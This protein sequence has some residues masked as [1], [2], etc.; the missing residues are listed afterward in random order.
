MFE[1]IVANLLNK[2][3]GDYVA[4]LET[5]QLKIGI[6]HG[7]VKLNNLQLRKE[8]LDK[9]N[10]PIDVHEGYIG[11]LVLKIPWSN[12]KGEPVRVLL[13]NIFVLAG[14]KRLAEYD[15]EEDEQRRQRRKQD[16]LE[17]LEMLSTKPKPEAETDA[18]QTSFTMQ[19]VTKIVDNL[20]ISIH[21]IHIRYE[22]DLSNPEHLFAAGI[23][24]SELSAVSTDE[25]WRVQFIDQ[26]MQS[27]FKLLRMGHLAV[28]F[29]SNT[30]SLAGQS[31]PDF[32]QSFSDLISDE[33]RRPKDQMYI[34]KPVS[35]IGRLVLNKKFT[36]ST[37]KSTATFLFDQLAFVLDDTQYKDLL[38]LV[39]SF[40]YSIRQHRYLK[41]R[42]PAH[43]KVSDNARQWLQFAIEC[44]LSEVK[45]RRRRWTWDYFKERR[46][47]RQR[48]MRLYRELQTNPNA[49]EEKK[50]LTALERK[51]SFQDIRFYRSRV[52]A[53]LRKE[54]AVTAKQ[55]GPVD[56]RSWV[57]SWFGAWSGGS[58]TPEQT[59][60]SEEQ[61]QELYDTIEF[62]EQEVIPDYDLPK[63]CVLLEVN[64]QLNKGSFTVQQASR[65]VASQGYLAPSRAR[66]KSRQTLMSMNF[67]TF[68]FGFTKHPSSFVAKLSLHSFNIL[69]GTTEHSLYPYL[70]NVQGDPMQPVS[71]AETSSTLNSGRSNS[72]SP[73][74]GEK[75]EGA[76]PNHMV[77]SE[78]AKSFHQGLVTAL[79]VPLGDEDKDNGKANQELSTA[80]N[81]SGDPENST[82]VSETPESILDSQAFDGLTPVN[83]SAPEAEPFFTL[84]FESNPLDARANSALT[85][86]SQRLNFFF[87]PDAIETMARFF[88]PP[89]PALDSVHTLILAA[90]KSMEGFKQ[91]TRS[92]LQFALE[93]HKTM[94]IQVDLDAPIFIIPSSFT[95]P[96]AIVTVLDSGRLKVHSN[97]V[98]QERIDEGRKK[99]GK[100]LT[101]EELEDL[102][103]LMYDRFIL[104]LSSTQLVVGQSVDK[105]LEALQD[106]TADQDG[107]LHVVNRINVQFNIGVS[108][109]PQ[110]PGLPKVLIDGHLPLLKLNFSDRKYKA[111][112][113]FVDMLDFLDRLDD[114][115]V[116]PVTPANS[117]VARRDPSK[118]NGDPNGR[119]TSGTTENATPAP[120][121]SSSTN[122]L[123]DANASPQPLDLYS[124]ALADHFRRVL[125]GQNLGLSG[126]KAQTDSP[127]WIQRSRPQYS[128]RDLQVAGSES[129]REIVLPGDVS[130]S[131]SDTNDDDEFFDAEA[132]QATD[133]PG[134]DLH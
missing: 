77:G 57:G 110:Y 47:D 83:T 89:V 92:G 71:R 7:D 70:V 6:W 33:N 18:K 30:A 27:V 8:A 90:G 1:A 63:E 23:T 13:K 117:L 58:T 10:L 119:P 69:D 66:S 91:Q 132:G 104:D 39:S 11:E 35:G 60:L 80:T 25:F 99:E 51:L 85:L 88:R 28:Y 44:V 134:D 68:R 131:G 53:M 56:T 115:P 96:H 75:G 14:P 22:D 20:Q 127:Q 121:T 42:P 108:I 67:D 17:T 101:D 12:L 37:P 133:Q 79:D 97:L 5:D 94:D 106:T 36:P 61:I 125:P 78:L 105:C 34:L 107:D 82:E 55:T 116:L 113:K 111:L 4:N 16:K 81:E 102:K 100:E 50:E 64:M 109:I 114:D 130:D 65:A 122:R 98:A 84:V 24:L 62:D 49:L 124:R 9:F 112:M 129:D 126:V 120:P 3:L 31:L 21:N 38:L 52:E 72:P 123:Q 103:S 32:L 48:Y 26:P 41:F 76:H 40:D 128:L 29:N 45:E 73:D 93:A 86:K 43:V 2:F 95:D 87:N 19:L 15:P 74:Q 46:N 118:D 59:Q 54:R